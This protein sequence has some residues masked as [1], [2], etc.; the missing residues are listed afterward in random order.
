MDLELEE[1]V[2]QRSSTMSSLCDLVSLSPAF[3]YTGGK[4]SMCFKRDKLGGWD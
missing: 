4:S 3:I 2:S 1:L